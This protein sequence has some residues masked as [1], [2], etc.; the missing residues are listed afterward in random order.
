MRVENFKGLVMGN[1]VVCLIGWASESCTAGDLSKYK[2]YT[3]PFP[4]GP[5]MRSLQTDLSKFTSIPLTL[6]TEQNNEHSI[7]SSSQFDSSEIKDQSQIPLW[8]HFLRFL[9]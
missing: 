4:F 6:F 1:D 7:E 5:S 2:T 9:H 8:S 3:E